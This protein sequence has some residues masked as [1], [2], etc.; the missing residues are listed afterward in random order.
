[1]NMTRQSSASHRDRTEGLVVGFVLKVV[2][3]SVNLTQEE[4]ADQLSV[5]PQTVQAWESGRRPLTATQ[6]GG[7]VQV[8]QRLRSLGASPRLLDSLNAALEADYIKTHALKNSGSADPREHPLAR[9]VFTREVSELLGWPFTGETPAGLRGVALPSRRGPVASAPV[10]SVSEKKVFFEH[11]RAAAEESLGGTEDSS[12][13]NVL[14]RRQAYYHLTWSKDPRNERVA[15]EDPTSR[16][17]PSPS[18]LRRMV[19]QVGGSAFT[20]S[21][22]GAGWRQRAFG[23]LHP[24]GLGF[25]SDRSSESPLLGLLGQREER[26]GAQRPLHDT[27][28]QPLVR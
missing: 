11:F 2:R 12:A 26:R 15:R 7:L 6:V 4:L 8:R 16:A 28:L 20:C 18:R 17:T 5:D 19:A 23:T 27:T 10:L 13:G 25:G 1:M 24:D 9:W 14:L 22:T 21:C 3:E